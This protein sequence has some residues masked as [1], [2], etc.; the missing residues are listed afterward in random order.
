MKSLAHIA[1]VILVLTAITANGQVQLNNYLKE[2]GQNNPKLKAHF[3]TYM[4]ALEKTN[5]VGVLPNPQ[6]AFGYFL[7]PIETRLGPQKAKIG[8]T[9]KFPWFGTLKTQ[10]EVADE[11]AKVKFQEVEEAKAKL[12]LQVR[13]SY[14]TLY[15]LNKAIHITTEN[16]QLLETFRRL[17]LIKLEAGIAS[18]V[19]ELRIE[20]EMGDLE[21]RLAYLQ[22]N[23]RVQ[24]VKF[25]KL[26]NVEANR[27]VELPDT[28]WKENFT[29]SISQLRD[30]VLRNNPKLST[31]K[32]RI[33]AFDKQ[34]DLAR[35]KGMPGF[36]IGADYIITGKSSV[37]MGDKVGNDAIIFPK[38][39]IS[40]PLY[41]KKYKAMVMEAKYKL[42][43]TEQSYTGKENE[44]YMLVEV[45]HRDYLDGNRRIQ[46]FREQLQLSQQA[47]DIL[48][49]EYTT[50]GK[51]FEEVLRME[52]KILKYALELDKA[53]ADNNAAFAFMNYLVGN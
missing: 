12:Y 48:L 36:T 25:N 19:D 38:V 47:L 29:I 33:L 28:L 22:D 2:A 17:A 37:V 49:A 32:H 52:R 46:L 31:L 24:T 39:G 41:R 6:V 3:F 26:L 34:E 13:S 20:M 5:Q 4:A 42:Q 27:K 35:K 7:E 11:M 16:L 10:V 43:S 40:V 50:K 53:R 44:L 1:S 15:F 9:Q 18:S 45:A 23:Y 51:N 14:Y 8:V 30:S 21:N